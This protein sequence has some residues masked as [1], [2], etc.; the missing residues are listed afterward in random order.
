M[1]SHFTDRR[2]SFLVRINNTHQ[3][4]VS[5]L[6]VI[7]IVRDY[8]SYSVVHCRCRLARHPQSETI[9]V[10]PVLS[11][12][13]IRVTSCSTLVPYCIKAVL[14]SR[15]TV[16]KSACYS[17]YPTIICH[18]LTQS[19]VVSGQA[20]IIYQLSLHI[21]CLSLASLSDK[22]SLNDL[23]NL[24]RNNQTDNDLKIR[25]RSR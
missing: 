20:I 12:S 9:A 25:C 16:L 13:I 19:L 11:L 6:A 10:M 1:Y 18:S 8:L 17:L 5:Q 2:W 15:C 7:M 21:P 4:V 14:T 3:P 22:H 23:A 24:F